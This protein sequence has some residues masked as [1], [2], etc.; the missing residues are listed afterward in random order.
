MFIRVFVGL[1][2]RPSVLQ[3]PGA[4]FVEAIGGY[5]LLCTLLKCLGEVHTVRWVAFLIQFTIYGI[6]RL[7][8]PLVDK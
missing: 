8:V 1:E 4:F 3:A 7:V 6:Y 2:L 5:Y